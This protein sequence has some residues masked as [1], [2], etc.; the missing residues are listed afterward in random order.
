MPVSL[1][2]GSDDQAGVSDLVHSAVSMQLEFP[3]SNSLSRGTFP[4]S[5]HSQIGDSIWA[6]VAQGPRP[7]AAA[8]TL[9]DPAPNQPRAGQWPPLFLAAFAK[10]QRVSY[11][12]VYRTVTYPSRPEKKSCP[13]GKFK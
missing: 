6:R 10:R 12:D 5:G 13:P 2:Q 1:V 9:S 7:P 8:D 3:H 4:T 11:K